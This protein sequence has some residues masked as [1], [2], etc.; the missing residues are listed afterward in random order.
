MPN[1][2]EN[3]KS[4]GNDL[5][6]GIGAATVAVAAAAA[7]AYFLYGSKDASKNRKTVKGWMLK[8]RGE[9]LEKIETMKDSLTE[10]S[11]NKIIDGV[12]KKYISM[13]DG[14]AAEADALSQELK[15]HWKNIKKHF[16]TVKPVRPSTPKVKS[17]SKSK[18]KAKKSAK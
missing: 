8:A 18:S 1:K 6:I 15:S 7:G 14:S 13:K 5:A 2:K 11:Y 4:N 17:K 12:V 9:V 16:T 10:E 3:K